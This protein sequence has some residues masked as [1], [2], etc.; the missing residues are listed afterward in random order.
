MKRKNIIILIILSL[1]II[2]SVIVLFVNFKRSTDKTQF[3]ILGKYI[4]SNDYFN[5]EPFIEYSD[6]IP[7][8]TFYDNN[9]C[10]LLVH[11]G[12]GKT[13]VSCSY[14]IKEKTIQVKLNIKGSFFDVPDM[15]GYPFIDDQYIFT[16]IDNNHIIID[17]GFYTVGSGDS[18]I[19]K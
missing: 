16:I 10:N 6:Y 14:D 17:K 19:K 15:E 11:Y 5:N 1:S 7:A 8:I 13:D 4:C 9:I 12:G 18:F 3:N 2:I